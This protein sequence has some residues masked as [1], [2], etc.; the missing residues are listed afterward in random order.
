MAKIK[1]EKKRKNGKR[2][3][4]KRIKRG[5]IIGG[6]WGLITGILYLLGI[7]AS[8]FSGGRDVGALFE[9]TSFIWK[10]I[11]LPAYLSVRYR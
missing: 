10:M 7:L 4:D 9:N 8:G 11:C 2:K 1:K 6:I 5:A 3:I